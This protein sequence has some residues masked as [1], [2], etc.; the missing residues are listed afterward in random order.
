MTS[1]RNSPQRH[2]PNPLAMT[3]DEAREMMRRL[4]EGMGPADVQF[5][6]DE[7]VTASRKRTSTEDAEERVAL[8][9]SPRRRRRRK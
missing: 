2:Y 6:A 9:L 1:N 7:L 3:P 8:E 4:W 5:T